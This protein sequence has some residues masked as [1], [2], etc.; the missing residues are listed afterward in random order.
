MVII[1]TNI[2]HSKALQNLPKL[3]FVVWKQTIWQPCSKR[4][5]LVA[6]SGGI[7]W[8]G[9]RTGATPRFQDSTSS[10]KAASTPSISSLSSPRSPSPPGRPS[11]QVPDWGR[12]LR[13]QTA[14]KALKER[15]IFYKNIIFS[16]WAGKLR[17]GLGRGVWS[18]SKKTIVIFEKKTAVW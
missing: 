8:V 13:L 6:A 10:S 4:G 2:F 14:A 11:T 3:R 16:S 1:Y 7:T 12:C 5:H 18:V 17:V 9:S 15:V